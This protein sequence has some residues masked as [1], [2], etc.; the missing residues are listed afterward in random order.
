MKTMKIASGFVFVAAMG[1]A[2][3]PP[4]VE[5][6]TTVAKKTYA[7]HFHR[8]SQVGERFHVVADRSEDMATKVTKDGAL[9][10][11]K[12]D[13]H[14][15]H[16]DAV[17]TVVA[18]DAHGRTTRARYEVKELTSDGRR[19][20]GSGIELT[21]HGKE[22]DAE[23]VVDGNPANEN[24]RKALSA[25][26]KLG[27]DGATDDDVFGT[28][29]PQPVGARWA[30]DSAVAVR[31]FKDDGLDVSSIHGDVWLDG[32]TRMDGVECLDIRGALHMSGI[33][34][35]DLPKGAEV[36]ESRADAELRATLPTEGRVARAADHLSMTMTFRLR[37]P[38]PDGAP[39]IVSVRGTQSQDSHETAM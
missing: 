17:S 20:Q 35:P 11:Q 6:P 31:S 23:I 21:R 18:T 13:E 7:V 2:G 38:G 36:D 10:S 27:L 25:L 28:K 19:L 1:C 8:P 12:H 14:T 39:M 15:I 5:A 24:V 33:R 34:L 29:T 22:T 37:V 26:F 30:I 9:V 3:S 32:T 16:C 4:P